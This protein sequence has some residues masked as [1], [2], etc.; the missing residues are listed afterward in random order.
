MMRGPPRPQF[1]PA[2]SDRRRWFESFF[3]LNRFTNA[4]ISAVGKAALSCLIWPRFVAPFRW[5]L[6]RQPLPLSPLPPAFSGY[7]LLQL[8][9]LHVGKTRES[10][11]HEVIARCLQEKPNLVVITGD[12]IDY[13]VDNV[14]I[15]ERVLQ[16][17]MQAGIPDGVVAIFG[18]HDYHEYSWRHIGRRSAQ[19]AIHKRLV[20]LLE[21]MGIRLLRNE[22]VRVVRGGEGGGEIAIV[23]MDEM[24]TD[25]ADPEVAFA[26]LSENDAVICLQ[27]NPDG[28]E[29]LKNFPWQYMLCGHSHGGQANFPLVGA[30]YVPMRHRQYLRGLF[31]FAPLARQ[32]MSQ[33]TMFVST[34]LGYSHPIRLRCAPEAT[35]FTLE[36]APIARTD[37]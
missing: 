13:G 4:V 36:P 27:H 3:L 14:E 2:V 29:V 32:N 25:R 18:N 34:G 15:L 12:L 28:V 30:L 23:G 37:F 22:Q 20:K 6:T 1:D 21:R 17:L 31:H 8:T 24:W 5:K 26:G 16:P 33:R 35:L 7:T 11:L 19:R 10:Y 9:D